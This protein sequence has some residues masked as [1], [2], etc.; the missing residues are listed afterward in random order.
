MSPQI[1]LH[2]YNH[3]TQGAK[4]IG[5]SSQIQHRKSASIFV[6]P[7]DVFTGDAPGEAVQA[8]DLTNHV[9]ILLRTQ[10]L[11]VGLGEAAQ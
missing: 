3:F 5:V 8:W 7:E 2:C 10:D 4:A 1:T 6:I 9:G 11:P